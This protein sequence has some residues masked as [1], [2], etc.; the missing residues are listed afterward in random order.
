MIQLYRKI[1]FLSCHVFVSSQARGHSIVR[2]HSN[3][4]HCVLGIGCSHFLTP[5]LTTSLLCSPSLPS[6]RWTDFFDSSLFSVPDDADIPRRLRVNV[7]YWQGNYYVCVACLLLSVAWARPPF[8]L[9]LLLNVLAFVVVFTPSASNSSLFSSDALTLE[10]HFSA[11]SAIFL[12]L[13]GGPRAVVALLVAAL[14]QTFTPTNTPHNQL[15]SR[16][17]ASDL[18]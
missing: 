3:E 17:Y 18:T 9:C 13:F 7:L 16:C 15:M 2:T 14:R 11:A 10:L 8:L 4:P 1:H 12:A 6:V 5:I